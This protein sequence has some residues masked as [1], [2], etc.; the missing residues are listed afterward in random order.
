[1]AQLNNPDM[2][3]I[4]LAAL[5]AHVG[6]AN[7]QEVHANLR[8]G[9][10]GTDTRYPGCNGRMLSFFGPSLEI[11]APFFVELLAE[12]MDTGGE[13]CLPGIITND[14]DQPFAS[15]V[16][17]E[18]GWR[19]GIG[20]GRRFGSERII[21][22]LRG[23]AFM[24]T[25]EPFGSGDLRLRLFIVTIGTEFGLVRGHWKYENGLE[26]DRWCKFGSVSVGL[27]F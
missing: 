4:C 23:G 6:I 25:H 18:P 12:K 26:Y 14:P 11:G 3:V 22:S 21:G 7:A 2:R 15:A 20:L 9:V 1:M 19:A 17:T 13:D 24:K 5:L 27:R 8:L 16:L 10:G